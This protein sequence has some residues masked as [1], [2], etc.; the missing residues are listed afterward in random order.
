MQRYLVI[1][2]VKEFILYD[3]HSADKLSIPYDAIE[4]LVLE[5]E[6]LKRYRPR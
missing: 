2:K 3:V 5:L 4:Y 1:P 6:K